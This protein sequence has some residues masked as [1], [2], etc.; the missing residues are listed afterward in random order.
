MAD[1]L[2]DWQARLTAY[3]AQ[4]REAP[5]AWGRHDCALFVAGAVE[6]MTGEDLAR[7]VR[8]YRSKAAGLAALQA[9]GHADHEAL[10]AALLEEV[11]PLL[12]RPGDVVVTDGEGGPALGIV[13]G[14]Q[15]YLV[16]LEGLGLAPRSAVRRAFRV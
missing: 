8:S 14:E 6:A 9:R 15:V 2:P 1:R 5:F 13:Q 4:V 3:L 12:A 16:G 11:P 10:A 7:G